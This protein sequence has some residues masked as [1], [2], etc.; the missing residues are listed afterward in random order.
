[1]NLDISLIQDSSMVYDK[2]IL[3]DI[4]VA[5][6]IDSSILLRNMNVNDIG[7]NNINDTDILYYTVQVIALHNPVDVSI[8]KHINDLVVMFNDDDKFYRY[9]TGRF[10]TREEAY[11][12]RRELIRKGY[13][14][15]IF[16]K[17]V[18]KN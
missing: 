10:S 16:I 1:M 14:D 6:S 8:F 5:E 7:D 13:P 12:L 11:G 17:K 3:T 4:P 15:E 9:T 18:S 2:I